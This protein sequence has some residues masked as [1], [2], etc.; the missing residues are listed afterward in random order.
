MKPISYKKQQKCSSLRS[1]MTRQDIKCQRQEVK[2]MENET[3]ENN[4]TVDKLNIGIG[5]KEMVSLEAK[6]VKI[7]TVSVEEQKTKEG[8]HVGEKVVCICK[9]PDKEEA[10][11]ISSVEYMKN[12]QI[13]TAGTWFNTDSD[14]KIQKGSALSFLMV[15][16][17]AASIKGLE[18]KDAETIIDDK[19]YLAFKAY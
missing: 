13:K 10:I 18:G 19:G 2:K 1:F 9:H 11:A 6:Q 17:G 5:N 14:D 7:L 15:K 4:E 12:K 16:L 3:P 8:K